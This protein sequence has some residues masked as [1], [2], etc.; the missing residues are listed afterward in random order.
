LYLFQ[1]FAHVGHFGSE[2]VAISDEGIEAVF[3]LGIV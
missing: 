1:R 2:G 3:G